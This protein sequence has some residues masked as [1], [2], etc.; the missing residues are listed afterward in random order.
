MDSTAERKEQLVRETEA[1]RQALSQKFSELGEAVSGV[2]TDAK[3]T[4]EDTISNTISNLSPVHQIQEHPI[5]ALLASV[6]GGFLVGRLLGGSGSVASATRSTIAS[7][8]ST[9]V[10]AAAGTSAM[11]TLLSALGKEFS[12]EL[13][14]AKGLLSTYAFQR[15][16]EYLREKNP[17]L[18]D[19]IDD[20]E[21]GFLQQNKPGSA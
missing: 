21:R 16:S 4:I 13:R 11:S 10:A 18:A 12:P 5:P 17:K 7:V 3:E 8:A 19:S 20:I 14:A 6:A 15:L 2:V 1:T 9:G